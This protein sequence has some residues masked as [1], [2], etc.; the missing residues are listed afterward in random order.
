[1]QHFRN[2]HFNQLT[3]HSIFVSDA[4]VNKLEHLTFTCLPD[5]FNAC[6]ISG[7]NTLAFYSTIGDN[8]MTTVANVIKL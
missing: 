1:M 3:K 7:T 2:K 4:A 6:N 5:W 8:D